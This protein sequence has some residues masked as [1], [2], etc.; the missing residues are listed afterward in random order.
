VKDEDNNSLGWNIWRIFLNLK[1]LNSSE[2]TNVFHTFY[3]FQEY[4]E[5]ISSILIEIDRKLNLWIF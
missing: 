2:M 5:I 4:Q 1:F 3:L